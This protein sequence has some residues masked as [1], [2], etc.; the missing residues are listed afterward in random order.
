MKKIILV[1]TLILSVHSY[2]QKITATRNAS[3]DLVGIAHKEDFK[4]F[5]IPKGIYFAP[6]NYDTG[7]QEEFGSPKAIIEAFKLRD[8]NKLNNKN[9]NI[10][11]NYDKL[12]KFRQ[13]Y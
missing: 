8:I 6:V 5:P 12:I 7:E 11:N 2:A 3:G 10:S 1:F 13:F 9:L 4:Q